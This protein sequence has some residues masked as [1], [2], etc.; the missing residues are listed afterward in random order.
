M[1]SEIGVNIITNAISLIE[2]IVQFFCKQQVQI[3]RLIFRAKIGQRYPRLNVEQ[4]KIKPRKGLLV[5]KF[6]YN[7][8]KLLLIKS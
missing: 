5:G 8:T 6:S 4:G 7:F 2:K 1:S 3:F